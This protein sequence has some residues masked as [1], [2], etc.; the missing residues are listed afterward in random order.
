MK[1]STYFATFL[2]DHVNLNP[3]RLNMLQPRVEAI[4]GVLQ[5]DDVVGQLV[6]D[7]QRQGS[8]AQETII[9][10]QKEDEFDADI[11]L[12]LD[13]VEGWEPRDYLREV[14]RALRGSI[15]RD[16]VEKKNRCVRVRYANEFHVD[17]VPTV[18]LRDGTQAIVNWK[19]GEFEL[20][21]PDAFTRWMRE[22]DDI[23]GGNLRRC[24]RLLKYTRDS[25]DAFDV[26]S[27]ILTLLLGAQVQKAG[28]A[29]RYRDIPTTLVS[30][31][32]DLNLD[33]Q[34]HPV[35]DEMPEIRL[36]DC[37]GPPLNHRLQD[38][39]TIAH[40]RAAIARYARDAAQAHDGGTPARILAGWQKVFG[41]AFSPAEDLD[42]RAAGATSSLLITGTRHHRE[43]PNEEF[44][45]DRHRF[46][47]RFHAEIS[48]RVRERA[49]FRER[50]LRQV[51]RVGPGHT[52]DFT[53]ITDAPG[54]FDLWWKVRNFGVEAGGDP[55]GQL[56]PGDP[57]LR[58]HQESTRYTGEHWIEAYAVTGGVVVAFAHCRVPV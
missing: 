25:K 23:T 27:V 11:L 17:V 47:P 26:P 18:A 22:R 36:P 34:R 6:L 20:T 30:L 42:S 9:R 29:E 24:I 45:E 21:N 50:L 56:M 1:Q 44:I 54:P 53:F 49:G 13:E 40:F 28:A 7:W 48:G 14:R 16:K 32:T 41:E 39:K 10:P 43:V 31:L 58:R 5:R 51:L 57:H 52:I 15:Y 33:L 2:D 38:P 3:T 19:T 55:R 12:E 4:F 8:W 35:A 46:A 37:P